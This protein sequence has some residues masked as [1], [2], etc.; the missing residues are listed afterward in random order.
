MSAVTVKLRRLDLARAGSDP[1]VAA[2][3][4]PLRVRGAVPD[5]RVREG[6]RAI[7]DSVKSGGDAAVR[8][9]NARFGGGRA[10][11]ALLVGRAEMDAARDALP[12]RVRDGLEQMIAKHSP[13]CRN[14]ASSD[15]QYDD[16]AGS[17]DRAALG[18]PF[19]RRR[20]CPGRFS[21]R[22]QARC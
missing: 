5:R 7:L 10:G 18:A 4:R 21:P 9:A 12:L 13:L 3:V 2:E 22:I 14:R 6:A 1:A 8:E 16:L 20:L 19:S 11:G 15:P 17:G